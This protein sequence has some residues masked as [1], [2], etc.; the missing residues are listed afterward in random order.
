M[1]KTLTIE[2]PEA[3][4]DAHLRLVAWW[5]DFRIAA[6]QTPVFRDVAESRGIEVST[7]DAELLF[8]GLVA[9][10]CAAC[11]DAAAMGRSSATPTLTLPLHV[12]HVGAR[13]AEASLEATLEAT[14]EMVAAGRV[15]APDE[16]SQ[17]IRLAFY[18][19]VA[20]I[21]GYD[22]TAEASPNA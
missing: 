15:R 4:A 7:S 3:P 6:T 2:L 18:R 17:E 11:A 12:W 10:V 19:R 8:L 9:S 16:D 20:D 14:R 21:L 22:I 5:C 13:T 1:E